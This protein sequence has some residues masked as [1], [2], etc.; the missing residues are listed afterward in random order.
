[1]RFCPVCKKVVTHKDKRQIFCNQQCYNLIRKGKDNP[2]YGHKWNKE[3]K[4][5]LALKIKQQYNTGRKVWNKGLTKEDPRVAKYVSAHIGKPSGM[6]GKKAPH[7]SKNNKIR[8]TNNNPMWKKEA[9]D[10]VSKANKGKTP[11]NKGIHAW[12]VAGKNNKKWKGDNWDR[13]SYRGS[14][15][16]SVIRQERLKR[17]DYKCVDCG[18]TEKQHKNKLNCSLSIHHLEPWVL[19][20][21]N[22]IDNLITLCVSCHQKREAVI[23]KK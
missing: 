9:R 20:H 10:K 2:N 14:S 15:W 17:D 7:T 5:T 8:N 18:I 12:Y 13:R 22:K 4:E 6:L 19:H 23:C 1:M 3:K 16:K 11:W 21:N